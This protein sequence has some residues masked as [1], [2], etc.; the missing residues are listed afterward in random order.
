MACRASGKCS[1]VVVMGGSGIA[2]ESAEV[3]EGWSKVT[4]VI[5]HMHVQPP[6][7]VVVAEIHMV[8][9]LMQ[10]S[11]AMSL[12]PVAPEKSCSKE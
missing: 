3:Q 4:A 12:A 9:G 6:R 2:E 11:N 1:A 5:R 8:L 7:G 10:W